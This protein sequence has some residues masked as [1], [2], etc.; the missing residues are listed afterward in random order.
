MKKLQLLLILCLGFLPGYSELLDPS[1][2]KQHALLK[3][4]ADALHAIHIDVIQDWNSRVDVKSNP[5]LAPLNDYQMKLVQNSL[6]YKGRWEQDFEDAVI[7]YALGIRTSNTKITATSVLTEWNKAGKENTVF[8]S[9]ASEDS[10]RAKGIKSVLERKGFVVFTYQDAGT[11]EATDI[12]HFMCTAGTCLVLDTKTART[13]SGVQAEALSFQ[14]Y[15]SE[16]YYRNV[17]LKNQLIQL[18]KNNTPDYAKVKVLAA[19]YMKDEMIDDIKPEDYIKSRLGIADE[20]AYSRI[21]QNNLEATFFYRL[22]ADIDEY[23]KSQQGNK[24]DATKLYKE[25]MQLT[26]PGIC[27]KCHL[28]T[29]F[30]VCLNP[31]GIEK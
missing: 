13:K 4:L 31:L 20:T 23:V 29:S 6:V 19:T 12:A 11:L 9:Y 28:P 2:Q 10:E 16:E 1:A 24:P 5:V 22:D 21:I 8:I 15:R 26:P 17:D 30:P 27:G 14:R 7:G 3:S 18:A 25:L